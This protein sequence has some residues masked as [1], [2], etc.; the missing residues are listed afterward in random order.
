MTWAWWSPR[1]LCGVVSRNEGVE[2]PEGQRGPEIAK[3]GSESSGCLRSCN[4]KLECQREQR[5]KIR[6]PPVLSSYQLT[7]RAVASRKVLTD[8][9][10][11][12]PRGPVVGRSRSRSGPGKP[13]VAG[14][15]HAA[16]S[17]G[18]LSFLHCGLGGWSIGKAV[19]SPAWG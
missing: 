17:R 9:T 12:E 6:A 7:S 15:V 19:R 2:L 13:R 16:R 3:S 10:V 4:W 11:L 5:E 1:R 8:K 18:S 14:P